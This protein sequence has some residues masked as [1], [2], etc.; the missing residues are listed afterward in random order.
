MD[1][2]LGHVGVNAAAGSGKTRLI[3]NQ[4]KRMRD[5]G[6]TVMALTLNT[7]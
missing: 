3:V 7:V 5:Q 1:D 4:A 6:K 2:A